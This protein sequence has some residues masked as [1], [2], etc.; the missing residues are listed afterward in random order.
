[1]NISILGLLLLTAAAG[2]AA[3]CRKNRPGSQVP[4]ETEVLV[5]TSPS[6]PRA[7]T[8]GGT[9]TEQQIRLIVDRADVKDGSL[10]IWESLEKGGEGEILHLPP[11]GR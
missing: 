5:D 11:V 4:K 8:D 9:L 3:G 10:T 6:S 1:M 7:G 2:N